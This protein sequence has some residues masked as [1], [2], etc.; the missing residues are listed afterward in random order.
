[1]RFIWLRRRVTAYTECTPPG[2]RKGV[3]PNAEFS[4]GDALYVNEVIAVSISAAL[5]ILDS[6]L[7]NVG[8]P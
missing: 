6:V 4:T 2:S 5:L 1:M 3:G 7:A 8:G